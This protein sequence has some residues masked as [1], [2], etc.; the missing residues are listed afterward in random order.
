[1]TTPRP[2]TAP[3]GE[4][5]DGLFYP[6]ED[7]PNELGADGPLVTRRLI[8]EALGDYFA[9]DPGVYVGAEIPWYTGA[10]RKPLCTPDAFVA[11][12]ARFGERVSWCLDREGIVPAVC[13]HVETPTNRTDVFGPAKDRC[14]RLGVKEYLVFGAD[15]VAGFR[16]QGRR[17]RAIRPGGDGGVRSR[18]LGLRLVS[19]YGYP[20]FVDVATGEVVLTRHEQA[21]RSVQAGRGGPPR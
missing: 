10:S 11:F 9:L 17:Y 14:E 6:S 20:R 12:G 21:L 18:L 16:L 4:Y 1:M 8:R 5:E 19:E 15:R 13:I 3:A 2:F 7:G